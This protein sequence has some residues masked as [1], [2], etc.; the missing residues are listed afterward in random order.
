MV[1]TDQRQGG[2]QAFLSG[3]PY[4]LVSV[5]FSGLLWV[6][7]EESSSLLPTE[8]K[9]FCLYPGNHWGG[10]W[11][12]KADVQVLT[13]ISFV[14]WSPALTQEVPSAPKSGGHSALTFSKSVSFI[15]CR[16]RGATAYLGMEFSGKCYSFQHIIS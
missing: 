11:D 8:Y 15:L 3:V 5:S 13:Q 9:L 1:F 7:R 6:L 14:R 10:G 2:D 12:L 16:G 4:R